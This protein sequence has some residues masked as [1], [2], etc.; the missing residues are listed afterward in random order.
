[1]SVEIEV[2]TGPQ[3]LLD[4]NAV[5]DGAPGN[6]GRGVIILDDGQDVPEDTPAG[7]RILRRP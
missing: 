5:A 7:T 1:M 4:V 3:L 6:D 2:T